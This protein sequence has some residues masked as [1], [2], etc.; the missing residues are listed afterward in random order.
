MTAHK[1]V[2]AFITSLVALIGLFGVSTG[3][4]T[5]SLIDSALVAP[6]SVEVPAAAAPPAATPVRPTPVPIAAPFPPVPPCPVAPAAPV[7]PPVTPPPPPMTPPGATP[8]ATT[9][10][11]VGASPGTAAVGAGAQVFLS[12]SAAP[13]SAG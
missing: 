9:G 8:G 12:N 7:A 2:A 1:A 4:V 3:W 6:I 13:R 11:T 10:T 5:P